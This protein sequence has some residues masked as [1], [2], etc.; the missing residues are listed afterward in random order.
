M[1]RTKLRTRSSPTEPAAVSGR[2]VQYSLAA[3]LVIDMSIS[4]VWK[5]CLAIGCAPSR[6]GYKNLDQKR[7]K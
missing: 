3:I 2:R 5:V 6:W 1:L 7:R 4:A